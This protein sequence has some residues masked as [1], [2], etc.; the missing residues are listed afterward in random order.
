MPA[1][2]SVSTPALRR[3][4]A[5]LAA[6]LAAAAA[7]AQP[8]DYP[9]LRVT[10]PGGATSLLIGSMHQGDARVPLVDPSLLDAA[11]R[12]VIEGDPALPQPT[13]W[14]DLPPPDPGPPIL[15]GTVLDERDVAVL[16]ARVACRAPSDPAVLAF[17]LRYALAQPLRI[18]S[19]MA[20]LCPA[21]G[22]PGLEQWVMDGAAERAVPVEPLESVADPRAQRGALPDRIFLSVVHRALSPDHERDFAE[23]ADALNAGDYDRVCGL[24]R[25]GFATAEDADLFVKRMLIERHARW[26]PKLEQALQEGRAVVVVGAAHLCG[27]IGLPALLRERGYRLDRVR[28][29]ATR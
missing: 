22:R 7:H 14:P 27:P 4:V 9:A 10:A 16:R 3:F 23:L 5:A 21:P 19:T 26:L 8:A 2:W 28:V 1:V 15:M 17:A 24:V 13:P 11:R 6:L 18:G 25:E 20:T 29:P 12:L